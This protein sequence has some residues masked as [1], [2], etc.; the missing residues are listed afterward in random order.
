M[1]TGFDG[2]CSKLK[3]LSAAAKLGRTVFGPSPEKLCC[4][5]IKLEPVHIHPGSHISNA[6]LE[7]MYEQLSSLLTCDTWGIVGCHRRRRG[8]SHHVLQLRLQ[9]PQYMRQTDGDP[10]LNLVARPPLNPPLSSVNGVERGGIGQVY[11]EQRCHRHQRPED[12][13]TMRVPYDL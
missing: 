12:H 9:G 3:W 11:T 10:R 13:C 5:S 6:R 2:L 7:C 4:V 8:V 1:V